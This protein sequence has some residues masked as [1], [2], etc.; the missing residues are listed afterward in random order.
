[1]KLVIHLLGLAF[2]TVVFAAPV[3]KISDFE[4]A[5]QEAKPRRYRFPKS[6][7]TVMAV[8]DRKGA[9]QLAP[10]I[11]RVRDRYSD[12][13]DIDGL[14][15]VS[16]IA[17]PFHAMLRTAFRKRLAYPVMLDWDGAVVKQFGYAKDEANI[18]VIDPRGCILKQV[19]GPLSDPGWRDLA[20]QIDRALEGT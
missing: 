3:T 2:T 10:W 12:R 14:A 13:V 8:A 15:D 17:K 5:D 9:T 1:M 4:L 7:V 16:M 6:K 19:T 18:Y 11:Q 20:E